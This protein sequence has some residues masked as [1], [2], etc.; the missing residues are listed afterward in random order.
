MVKVEADYVPIGEELTHIR[1][2]LDF[3]K[4]R[5]GDSLDYSITCEPALEVVPIPPFIMESFVGNSLKYGMDDEDH[6]E[7]EIRIVQTG[8]FDLTMV[9]RDHGSGFPNEILEAVHAF[10]NNSL[11]EQDKALLGTGI[12]NS[13]ERL[14]L[15]YKD[16]A[17]FHMY[18]DGGAVTEIKLQL[19]KKEEEE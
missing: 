16:R 2:Y 9:I 14:R 7:I 10:E 12:R 18:N 3:Q 5:F 19:Q 11:S 13:I 17:A 8:T 6:I 15:I 1:N 4:V